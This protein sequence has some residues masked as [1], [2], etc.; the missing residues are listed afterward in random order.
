MG[1]YLDTDF[2]TD[3]AFKR[4]YV[5]NGKCEL[6]MASLIAEQCALVTKIAFLHYA[7]ATGHGNGNVCRACTW[8]HLDVRLD[9]GTV[10]C[11][12]FTQKTGLYLDTDTR[13]DFEGEKKRKDS[14]RS[15]SYL[16]LS[17]ACQLLSM[18]LV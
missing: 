4:L 16:D 6:D 10:T 11:A 15:G 18:L 2:S 13:A 3:D 9:M 8:K 1:L 12:C 7:S 17:S 14:A 5:W